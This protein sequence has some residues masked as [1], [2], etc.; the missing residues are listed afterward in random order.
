MKP[1][2]LAIAAIAIL[3]AAAFNADKTDNT[4]A[5]DVPASTPVAVDA[6]KS[7]DWTEVVTKTDAGG[8]MMG[9]PNAKI[10]LIEYGSMTCP[11]CAA[12]VAQA[13]EPLTQKYVKNGQV[14]FEFRNFV[15]DPFDVTASLITRCGGADSFFPLTKAMYADQAN[16]VQKIQAASPQQQQALAGMGPEQEFK[17]IADLAG[18]QTWAAARGIPEAKT[19]ACLTDQNAVSQLVQMNNDAVSQYNVP[20]TPT[21]VINGKVVDLGTATQDEVWPTLESKIK[22][23]L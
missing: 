7:G 17:A 16:W 1:S 13:Y 9:N 20:G 4:V 8:F 21:F 22:A 6:P 5:A 11:H 15:R 19:N 12:F 14:A 18:F 10:K 23:A 3:G 2:H